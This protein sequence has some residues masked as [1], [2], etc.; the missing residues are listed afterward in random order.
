M[1][2]L[3]APLASS[4]SLLLSAS[5]VAAPPTATWQGASSVRA[6]LQVPLDLDIR[7]AK[8]ALTQG[9]PR[10]LSRLELGEPTWSELSQGMLFRFPLSYR[11][12]KVVGRRATVIARA[13]GT[14]TARVGTV[15]A[16]PETTVP[17][18]TLSQAAHAASVRVQTRFEPAH[19]SLVIV[20]TP[21]GSRLAYSAYQGPIGGIPFAPLVTVD[22]QTG[23][24]LSAV[25]AAR[26]DR[27]ASVH[28]ENPASTPELTLVTLPLEEGATQLETARVKALN[29]IDRGTV[30]KIFGDV[31]A[32]TCDLT[33][34]ALADEAGDFLE[35]AYEGDTLPEDTYAEVSIFYHLEKVYSALTELGMDPLPTQPIHGVV[36]LRMPAGM[37]SFDLDKM[38]DPDVPLE[39]YDNAFFAPDDGMFERIFG[40][41]GAALWFGQ[42]NMAD[43]AYDGDVVYH[44]FGHAVVDATIQLVPTWHVD[45]QGAMPSPGAL[46]EGIADYLSSIVTGDGQVG[47]YAGGGLG[48]G[49]IRSLDNAD[50]CPFGIGGE[51]HI[52]STFFSGALWEVRQGL[53]LE[54]RPRFDARILEALK[55]APSGDVSYA[56]LAVQFFDAVSDMDVSSEFEA[57]FEA[58]G[59]LPACDR[60]IELE[61][62][63][64][65]WGASFHTASG[66]FIPG[67]QDV[68]GL[69]AYVP[70]PVQFHAKVPN[71]ATEVRFT[72]EI[73]HTGSGSGPGFGGGAPFSPGLLVQFGEESIVFQNGV[74][75]GLEP[76]D[77]GEQT[78]YVDHAL[79]VPEGETAVT[80]VLVNFGD[81]SALMT[82]FQVEFD[83]ALPEDH[84]EAGPESGSG[85]GNDAAD[86]VEHEPDVAAPGAPRRVV[87]RE[88]SGC[89]VSSA[90][91]RVAGAP[92]GVGLA[93]VTFLAAR[94]RR[95]G[96]GGATMGV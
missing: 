79:P 70:A 16:L 3:F 71:G 15:S 87:S 62:G 25:N 89:A 39:P 35:H 12:V 94:R 46:N 27:L 65:Y 47:E 60:V 22:A 24:I 75:D 34:A 30:V 48:M 38:A 26:T 83:G 28:P 81:T 4:L 86:D 88:H 59:I 1:P 20:P 45:E 18:I 10:H 21:G 67:R 72:A 77:F 9:F 17:S 91:A 44:E 84:S 56:E 6:E 55:A 66:V 80:F 90:R 85:V 61:D 19:L 82:H 23:E 43:F 93:F 64:P 2:P 96:T 63:V 14:A 58:R 95:R 54:D 69:A 50:S 33:S 36:N 8:A 7:S 74:A 42:G 78:V 37:E 13:D 31:S 57:V 5:A 49:A 29:C 32:H 40:L 51:V 11:G 68:P 41:K 52:D 53:T 76:A 92:I 73:P